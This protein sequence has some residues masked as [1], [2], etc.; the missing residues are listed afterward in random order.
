[1]PTANV[2]KI[3]EEFVK[4]ITESSARL[5]TAWSEAVKGAGVQNV[6]DNYEKLMLSWINPSA[7]MRIVDST[8]VGLK[9]QELINLASQDLP[10]IVKHAGDHEKQSRQFGE[11]FEE[12]SEC[13]EDVLL[14][15]TWPPASGLA[16]AA[17]RPD[18]SARLR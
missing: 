13:H 6:Y 3:S 17:S 18:E 15:F 1:M 7:F 16:G 9:F 11:G 5:A 10:E 14:R 12:F 8:S 4:N 2:T